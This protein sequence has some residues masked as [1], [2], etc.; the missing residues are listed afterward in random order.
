MSIGTTGDIETIRKLADTIER[1]RGDEAAWSRLGAQLFSRRTLD[2]YGNRRKFERERAIPAG[3]NYKYCY[4]LEGGK[5]HKVLR[6]ERTA[7]PVKKMPAIAAAYG[8]TLESIGAALDGGDLVPA[9]GAAPAVPAALPPGPDG[10]R[11][12]GILSDAAIIAGAPYASAIF[13]RLRAFPPGEELP[14]REVFL[15]GFT[16]IPGLD[17][18]RAA[19]LWNDYAGV[20]PEVDLVWLISAVQADMD[21]AAQPDSNVG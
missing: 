21:A 6:W 10:A 8:V 9:P 5:D 1:H 15:D 2:G 17:A 14:G 19:G 3:L 11:R 7:F 4:D 18:D 13:T 16:G 12:L 20:M